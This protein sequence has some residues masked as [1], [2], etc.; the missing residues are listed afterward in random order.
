L[1][2]YLIEIS[3]AAVEPRPPINIGT[4]GPTIDDTQVVVEEEVPDRIAPPVDLPQREFVAH[5]GESYTGVRVRPTIENPVTTSLRPSVY[6]YTDGALMT[7]IAVKPQYPTAASSRDLG[8][9]VIVKFDV[10]AMGTVTNVSVVE[11]SSP[12]F[13]RSAIAA[14]KKFRF[15]PK[16]TGGVPRESYGVTRLF[17]YEMDKE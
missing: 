2:Q 3:E 15:K 11:S 9:Y 5:P 17:T 14:V 4:W 10:T 13:H 6:G 12:M 16:V 7:I 1:M 8:G